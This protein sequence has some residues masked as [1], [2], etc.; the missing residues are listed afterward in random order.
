MAVLNNLLN[1]TRRVRLFFLQTKNLN[2]I[3]LV[4]Q[5]LEFF[6]TI[7]QIHALATIYLKH[8]NIKLNSLFICCNLEY[9]IDGVFCDRINRERLARSRLP[10]RKTCH[11]SVLENYW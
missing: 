5:Y 2:F 8:A 11:D 1:F 6:L 10:I 4:L 7:Q 9:I 3:V